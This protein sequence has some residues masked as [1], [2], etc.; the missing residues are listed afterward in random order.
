VLGSN[1]LTLTG[2]INGSGGLTKSGG[3]TLTLSGSGYQG[4]TNLDAGILRLGSSTALG[5]G[6]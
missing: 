5:L 4:S 1:D 3:T 2:S 6:T